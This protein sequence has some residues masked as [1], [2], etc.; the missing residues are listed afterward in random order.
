MR[1]G[2]DAHSR[3]EPDSNPDADA[4]PHPD[5]PG[6][7]DPVRDERWTVGAAKSLRIRGLL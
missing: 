3:T 7:C 6:E 2:A 1:P 4:Q 5:T